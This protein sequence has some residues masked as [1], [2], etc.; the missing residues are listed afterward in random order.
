LVLEHEF[1]A[2]AP[3]VNSV[4]SHPPMIAKNAALFASELLVAYEIKKP[5]NWLPGDKIIRK[6]WWAYPLAMTIIHLKNGVANI[7]TQ[8]PSQCPAPPCQM[9]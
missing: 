1:A 3:W 2:G 9:P 8:P 7:R 5:H 4:P 6:L